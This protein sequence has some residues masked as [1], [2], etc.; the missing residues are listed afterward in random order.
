MELHVHGRI[1]GVLVQGFIDLLDT[2]GRIIDLKTAAKKP[3]EISANHKFQVATYRQLCPQASG[4]ARVDTLT[5]T[6]VPALIQMDCTINESDRAATEKLYPAVQQGIRAGHFLPNR[7]HFMCSKR[8]CGFWRTCE[9]EWGG[10]VT[11]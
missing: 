5:K 11:E 3:G 9:K 7:A 8:Y 1:G 6:K 10:R 2:D 4:E